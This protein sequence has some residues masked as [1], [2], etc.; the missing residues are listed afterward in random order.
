MKS[1]IFSYAAC[2]TSSCGR[3]TMRMWRVPGF[4][5]KPGAVH[6]QHVL[7]LQQVGDEG[8]VVLGNVQRR[9]RIERSLRLDQAHARRA[10]RPILGDLRAAVQLLEHRGN[11][12]L[13]TFQRRLDGVLKRMRRRQAARATADARASR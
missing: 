13:R 2:S 5:P 7:L 9:M 1:V 10:L 6:H 4:S 12:V 11:V 8:Q 3:N